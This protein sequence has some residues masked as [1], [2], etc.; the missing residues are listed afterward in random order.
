MGAPF[1]PEETS[2]LAS[3]NDANDRY[4]APYYPEDGVASL[5][6]TS[7]VPPSN[8]EVRTQCHNHLT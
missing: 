6:P 4:R 3:Q 7:R 8:L 2:L 5:R 1:R